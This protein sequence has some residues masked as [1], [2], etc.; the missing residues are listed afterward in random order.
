MIGQVLCG[1]AI[2]SA[3]IMGPWKQTESRSSAARREFVRSNPCPATGDSY[4]TC[5][6]WV[7][8]HKMPLCAG[9]EDS[10]SNMQWQRAD[11]AKAKDRDERRLCR[12]IKRQH[13]D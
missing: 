8:D 10:A 3:A 9:G 12:N 2:L 5:P 1:V 7:V 13:K 4:G 11:D 6:G